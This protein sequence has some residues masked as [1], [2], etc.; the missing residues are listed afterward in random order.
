MSY[1]HTRARDIV[2]HINTCVALPTE[3]NISNNLGLWLHNNSFIINHGNVEKG[4][5]R[6]GYKSEMIH[7]FSFPSIA[8]YITGGSPGCQFTVDPCEFQMWAWLAWAPT[9]VP[10]PLVPNMVPGAGVGL[11]LRGGQTAS[12]QE[13]RATPTMVALTSS[14]PGL[15]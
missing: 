3:R 7:W 10:A 9:T 2:T 5:W 12:W 13:A 1:Q 14:E 8:L 4:N 11:S 15:L 6:S